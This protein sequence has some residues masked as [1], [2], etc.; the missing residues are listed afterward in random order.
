MSDNKY[1]GQMCQSVYKQ[2]LCSNDGKGI[3]MGPRRAEEL[4]S[5][6]I[7]TERLERIALHVPRILLPDQKQIDMAKWSVIACDQFTSQREYWEAV[8]EF[9]GNA[10]STLNIIFPEAYFDESGSV[11]QGKIKQINRYMN[12]YLKA[13]FMHQLPPGFVLVDRTT[14]Q[15]NN[16]KGLVVALD[17]EYYSYEDDR[18]TLVRETERH[19]PERLLPRVKIRQNASLETT[20]VMVLIDDP[21]RTVIEPLFKNPLITGNI[22]YDFELMQGSGRI[23]GYGVHDPAII[24]SIA[25][26]LEA[27]L[28]DTALFDKYGHAGNKGRV[29]YAMGDGNHSFATAKKIWEEIKINTH[30]KKILV[31][32]P[33]RYC[34]VELVNIHD[35]GLPFHPIS[36]VLYDVQKDPFEYLKEQGLEFD[37]V[38][39]S[40]KE[41]RTEIDKLPNGS[42]AQKIGVIKPGGEYGVMTIMNPTSD[43][44]V[45]TLQVYLEK[46]MDQKLAR[47]IDYVHG[48]K[49]TEKD[50]LEKGNLGFYLPVIDK[51]SLIKTVVAAGILPKKAFSMGEAE[52]KRFYL[53]CRKL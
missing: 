12:E 41:M 26:N 32:H 2:V 13:G 10:P 7:D 53:E 40:K 33:A 14:P 50:S 45:A 18:F 1:I 31:D 17:L 30:D 35:E 9:V 20:H 5:K 29:L 37:Y 15:C 46:F 42:N 39:M 34:L 36:R 48:F 52:E 3:L 21:D 4:Q 8:K 43:L 25:A 44:A 38:A 23:K 16:R 19:I 51:N 28:N 24:N 6:G 47:K 27:L 11:D 49:A 22:L